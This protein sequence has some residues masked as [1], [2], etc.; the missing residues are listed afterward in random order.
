[1]L[2][3]A[4]A[5]WAAEEGCPSA[6]ATK[7]GVSD[8]EGFHK[9]IAPAWHHAYPDSNFDALL[10]AGPEFEKAFVPI[11]GIEARMKNANRKAA[12]LLNREQFAGLVKR[13][14]AACKAG[15]KD[16]VYAMLPA[17]HEAFEMT[18]F[19]CLP[20]SYPEF[21][22]IVVTVNLI[23]NTHLPKDNTEGIVGSTETLVTKAK[24]LTIESLPEDL[25]AQEKGIAPEFDAI[26]KLANQMQ[27]CC[28]KNDMAKYKPLAEE[29]KGKLA[30]FS[31]AYL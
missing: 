4:T 26:Q 29:L 15:Q 11:A 8:F 25:R 10:A 20:T 13:Y 24:G 18:A 14:A 1:M 23:L 30:A 17:L 9:V 6:K 5:V 28:V 22:G 16:S 31:E 12:F 27:E 21:D 7:A 19:A 2:L 3:A